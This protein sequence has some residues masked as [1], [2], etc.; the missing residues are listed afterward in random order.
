LHNSKELFLICFEK[1]ETQG[2]N[3]TTLLFDCYFMHFLPLLLTSFCKRFVFTEFFFY[4]EKNKH[5][6]I[7]IEKW[8]QTVDPTVREKEN[9][10]V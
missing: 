8:K 2:N 5:H 1:T 6:S 10:F 3:T 4:M 7:N 9:N